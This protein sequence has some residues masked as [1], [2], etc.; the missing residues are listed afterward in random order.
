MLIPSL[1]NRV[2]LWILPFSATNG[3]NFNHLLPTTILSPAELKRFHRIKVARKQQEFLSSRMLLRHIVESYTSYCCDSVEAVPDKMG[4]PF[5]YFNKEKIHLYFNLSHSQDI[6]CCAVSARAEIGCDIEFI[7]K[8]KYIEELTRKVFNDSELDFYKSLRPTDRLSFF[9]R[10]WTLKEAYVKA[11]GKGL[12]IPLTSFSFKQTAYK[13]WTKSVLSQTTE[14]TD[15]PWSF[16]T[17]S[18]QHGYIASLATVE[19][20]PHFTTITA[21][22]DQNC[23]KEIHRDS[24]PFA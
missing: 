19:P 9:Y 3:V 20:T 4:R 1:D 5:F 6:I 18:P 16:R 7:K 21:R 22:I 17:F 10:T 8:R 24:K 2:D 23:I 12:R 13:N 15:S 11:V 14:E